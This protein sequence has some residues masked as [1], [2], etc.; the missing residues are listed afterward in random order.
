MHV[1]ISFYAYACK[2]LQICMCVDTYPYIRHRACA[3]AVAGVVLSPGSESWVLGPSPGSVLPKS[4]HV[5]NTMGSKSDVNFET[6][7]FKKPCFSKWK[8]MF[9]EIQWVEVGNKNR[10]KN[11]PHMESKMEFILASIFE[12]CWWIVGANLVS[13]VNPESILAPKIYLNILRFAARC[14]PS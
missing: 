6:P 5:V 9:F 1:C 7:F 10:P 13:K 12:R 8:T 3:K 2:R 14:I 4:S 11:N